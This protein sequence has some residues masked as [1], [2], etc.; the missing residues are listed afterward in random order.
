MVSKYD[1][2][3]FVNF[4]NFFNSSSI[5]KPTNEKKEIRALNLEKQTALKRSGEYI[6]NHIYQHRKSLN[7]IKKEGKDLK[8]TIESQFN[9]IES[10]EEKNENIKNVSF[11]II[12][13]LIDDQRISKEQQEKKLKEKNN[14][15]KLTILKIKMKAKMKKKKMKLG[16]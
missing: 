11:E 15:Q 8:S 16:I 5:T 2:C 12:E 4:F 9:K 6:L 1:F 13:N 3:T 14:F 10:Y 7:Q